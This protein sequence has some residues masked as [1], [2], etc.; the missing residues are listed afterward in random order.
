[1]THFAILFGS[2]RCSLARSFLLR[3]MA[4]SSWDVP[5]DDESDHSA[6][7]CESSDSECDNDDQLP[8]PTQA[9]QELADYLLDLKTRGRLSARDVCVISHLAKRAGVKGATAEFAYKPSAQSGKFQ[10]H[11]DTIIKPSQ[12]LQH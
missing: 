3:L 8:S 5:D 11:L 6:W 4:S 7:D 1:M 2:K 9:S 12:V 10:A